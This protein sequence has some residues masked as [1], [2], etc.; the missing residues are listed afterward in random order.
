MMKHSLTMMHVFA[1]GMIIRVSLASLQLAF[2][3]SVAPLNA[4]SFLKKI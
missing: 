2:Q 4:R 1:Q 3:V